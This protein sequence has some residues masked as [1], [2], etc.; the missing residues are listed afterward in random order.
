[1]AKLQEERIPHG[2]SYC[3]NEVTGSLQN[4]CGFSCMPLK[5]PQSSGVIP[6]EYKVLADGRCCNI[7][8]FPLVVIHL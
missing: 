6:C 8:I 4:S 2:T 3:G 7:E 1:M 5:T